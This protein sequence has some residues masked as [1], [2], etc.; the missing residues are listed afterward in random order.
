IQVDRI[1]ETCVGAAKE[2]AAV[3][4]QREA[5]AARRAGGTG[6]SRVHELIEL[7]NRN[8]GSSGYGRRSKLQ[9]PSGNVGCRDYHGLQVVLRRIFRIAKSEIALREG[10]RG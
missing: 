4:G 7:S 2:C 6:R 9:R 10:M 5:E 8:C 3:V 1:A